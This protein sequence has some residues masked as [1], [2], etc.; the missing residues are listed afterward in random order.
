MRA[1]PVVRRAAGA[2][3]SHGASRRVKTSLRPRSGQQGFPARAMLTFSRQRRL[4]LL[5]TLDAP[6]ASLP[7]VELS[8][9]ALLK[10]LPWQGQLRPLVLEALADRLVQVEARRAGLS[11]AAADLQAAADLFRRRHGLSAAADSHAW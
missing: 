10:I 4:S 1:A 3:R 2:R 6:M 8:P 5:H 9:G 7:G 11:V